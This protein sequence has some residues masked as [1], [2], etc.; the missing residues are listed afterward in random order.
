[1][2]QVYI[3]TGEGKGKTS[4]ALGTV[5]RARAG[6]LK[7]AWV[8]WYK[9]QAWDVG[10]YHIKDLLGVELF[11]GGKG[12]YFSDRS[13]VKPT[14]VGAVVD[15]ASEADHKQAAQ[16]TLKTARELVQSQKYDLVIL[17]EVCQAAAEHMIQT[18][19]LV[20]LIEERGKTHLVLTGR[21]CPRELIGL[22]D[23]VTEMKKIKHAYDKGMRAVK[24]L[25][26]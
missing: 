1:M 22:A 17:D 19:D 5:L 8:A 4:A 25:D 14:R 24:G 6:G 26:F 21:H 2:S 3:F 23:T 15:K 18:K 20:G 16:T 11:I 12:F 7:V 9:D 13:K 10:D